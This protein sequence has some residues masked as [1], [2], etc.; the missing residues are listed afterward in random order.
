MHPYLLPADPHRRQTGKRSTL[1]PH[2]RQHILNKDVKRIDV[3]HFDS[4]SLGKIFAHF[5]PPNAIYDYLPDDINEF[6]V[7]RQFVL[8]VSHG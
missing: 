1:Q 4:L 2:S 6:E 8:D 3:P 5:A 7:N